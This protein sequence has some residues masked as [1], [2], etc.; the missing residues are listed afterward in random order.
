MATVCIT[1]RD[2]RDFP[3]DL[4]SPPNPDSV[5]ILVEGWTHDVGTEE[6]DAFQSQLIATVFYNM[7]KTIGLE[8]S[9][10]D[11]PPSS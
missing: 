5:D 1:I 4:M 11:K 3:T 10:L 2:N 9:F 6:S 7:L 8:G